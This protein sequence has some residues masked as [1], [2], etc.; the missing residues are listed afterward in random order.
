MNKSQK[1]A[2]F[3]RLAIYAAGMIVL[4]VGIT[5]NTKTGLGVSPIISIPFTIA[6][7]WNLNFGAMT[8]LVYT[9]FVGLQFILKG[10][11][12]TWLDLLQIPVSLVFSVLLNLFSD[13]LNISYTG[14]WQNLLLLLAA[15][16]ITALGIVMTV[17]MRLVPNPGDG[18]AQATGYALH[19][20]VGYGKNVLDFTCVI[21]SLL[22]GYLVAGEAAAIG[23]GTLLAMVGVGRFIA[24]L[25][26]YLKARMEEAAG[27]GF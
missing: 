17:N 25:N 10:K 7:I 24:L 20:G 26:H 5:L 4:A 3:F 27:I 9:V 16:I 1:T 14:L 6:T 18:M 13:I 21:L 19:K 22:M 12:R 2:W 11:S 23:I 8:F 15:I